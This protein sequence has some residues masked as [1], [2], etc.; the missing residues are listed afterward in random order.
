[1]IVV[2]R[3]TKY[4]GSACAVRDLSFSIEEGQC[5]GFLG[6]N[7]AGK[8][9]T[10]RLLSCL[11]LP[12]SGRVTIRGLDVEESPDEIR[13][14]IGYLPDTPPLY[15][16]MTVEQFLSFAGRLRGM[17]ADDVNHR[18]DEV[19]AV[20]A[21]KEVRKKAVSAL[22]HGYKQR[23]GIAQAII[24][25]PALLILDEPLQGLDPVQIVEMREMI[26]GLRGKHTILLSTHMLAE[27]EQTCDRILMLSRGRI[28]AEGSEED[29]ANRFGHAGATLE[30]DV[31]GEA[32]AVRLALEGVGGVK[33]TD[34]TATGQMLRVRVS[35]EGEVR[36]E[37]AKRIVDA[38]LGLRGFRTSSAGL[39]NIFV[40]LSKETESAPS[41]ANAPAASEE[42]PS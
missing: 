42:A 35:T 21:L 4:Y 27:I 12:T 17:S 18:M 36:E 29:L 26:R 28:A 1:M 15:G 37:I 7:G 31:R 14:F 22:S 39:E 41:A 33:V 2:D 24:H 11:L 6:L 32:D 23:V 3:V 5:I 13:K 8:S 19:L 10:L 40:R 38:G 9:T 20:C 16:E 34:V 30:L 25:R